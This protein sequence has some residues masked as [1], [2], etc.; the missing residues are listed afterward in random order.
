LEHKYDFNLG[1]LSNL[2]LFESKIQHHFGTGKIRKVLGT[3]LARYDAF[4]SAQYKAYNDFEHFL[5][6]NIQRKVESQFA[7]LATDSQ[8]SISTHL[9]VGI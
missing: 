1:C 9:A 4:S 6:D 5:R 8:I 7:A 3:Y 2:E